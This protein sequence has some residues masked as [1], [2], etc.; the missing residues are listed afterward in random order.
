MTATKDSTTYKHHRTTRGFPEHISTHCTPLNQEAN[1]LS[2]QFV[3][4]VTLSDD[5]SNLQPTSTPAASLLPRLQI[6][7]KLSFS[8]GEGTESVLKALNSMF[9]MT[10]M[11]SSIFAR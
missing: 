10:P 6:S 2:C 8:V 1:C 11:A 9:F 3:A 5:L 4:S 7:V